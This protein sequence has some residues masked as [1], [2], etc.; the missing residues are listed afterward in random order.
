MS[1]LSIKL[2]LAIKL[3]ALRLLIHKKMNSVCTFFNLN[4]SNIFKIYRF[5][6]YIIATIAKIW[7]ITKVLI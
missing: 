2:E 3:F 4:N 1:F 5:L 6:N 7:S